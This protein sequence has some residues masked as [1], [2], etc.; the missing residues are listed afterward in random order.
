MISLV[1]Q[2]IA[3]ISGG[4]NGNGVWSEY[5]EGLR[6]TFEVL[7]EEFDDIWVIQLDN[8]VLDDIHYVYIGLR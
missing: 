7:N 3:C 2:L 1:E 8:D 5:F 6:K 4:K